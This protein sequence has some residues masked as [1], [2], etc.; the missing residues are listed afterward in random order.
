MWGP[1][2]TRCSWVIRSVDWSSSVGELSFRDF[3]AC[4]LITLNRC[5]SEIDSSNFSELVNVM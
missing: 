4:N 3:D 1:G 2:F 5:S